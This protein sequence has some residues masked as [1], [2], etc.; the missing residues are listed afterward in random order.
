MKHTLLKLVSSLIAVTI[1][2]LAVFGQGATA[3]LSGV[4][5]DPSG[6]VVAG[7]AIVVKNNATSA[8]SKAVTASNGTFSVPA[9]DPG[10]YT[11]TISASGF[12]QAVVNDV[13]LDADTPG[14]VRVSLEIGSTNETINI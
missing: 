11:V 5:T 12:K 2:S 14:T 13:K 3:P 7:A 8:E 4:V 9:L 10:T 1:L 6:A